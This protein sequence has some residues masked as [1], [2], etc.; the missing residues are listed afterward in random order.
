M[1]G[2]TRSHEGE[3]VLAVLLKSFQR[4]AYFP[5]LE[6]VPPLVVTHVRG[7][8]D[9]PAGVRAVPDSQ[10]SLERHKSLVRERVKVRLD[11]KEAV[12][13]AEVAIRAAALT[14][15]NP[16]DLINVALEELIAARLELPGFT[17]LE[18]LA[19]A[20]REEVNQGFFAGIERRASVL[21]K[22]RLLD[23]LH[24]DLYTRRSRFD[25]LKQPA[26]RPS[27]SRLKAHL[28][29][30]KE[31][32]EEF[33]ATTVWPR[34]GTEFWLEGVPPAKIVHFAGEARVMD[35]SEM[36]DFNLPKR[37]ALLACLVH[38]ARVRARDELAGML[39]RRMAALHKKG[40]EHLE[41]IRERERA[42]TERLWGVFGEVLAGARVAIGIEEAA[43]PDESAAGGDGEA[44]PAGDR[45]AGGESADRQSDPDTV[46]AGAGPREQAPDQDA[47]AD[48]GTATAAG[49][50][51]GS[52]GGGAGEQELEEEIRAL[53]QLAGEL[54]LDPLVKAG[55]VSVVSEQHAEISAHHGN[56]YMPLLAKYFK[57]HRKALFDLLDQ[58]E[59][60]S[61]S[62]DISVLD[63][64]EF[65]KAHRP[66]TREF[67][68]DRLKGG[69][70]PL[71]TRFCSR[72]WAAVIRDKAH[73]GMFARRH[74][75]VC[76]F[77]YL[78]SELKT[79]DIA[80]K[81]ADSYGNFLAQLMTAAEVEPLIGRYCAEAGL[82]ASASAFRQMIEDKLKKTTADVDAG[83]P[84]NTDLDIDEKT[85]QP[86]L[87][88]RR[89]KER[90]A[91]AI[92]LERAVAQR[93]QEVALLDIV[94]RTAHWTGWWR[95]F[96]P[97]SG[98]DPKISDP[99]GRYSVITF[100]YGT[101][102]GPYQ[103]SRHLRGAVSPHEISAPGNKHVNAARLVQ[104]SG[105]LTDAF[106]RLDVARLWGDG[107]KVGADGT[108]MDTWDDNLLAETSVRYGGYGGIA[109]RHIADSYIALFS[110]FIPCGVWE[111]VYL[112]EGL[113]EHQ[114]TSITPGEIHADTQGQSL[115]VF[116]LATMLGVE[117]LPRIRNWKDLIF[118]RAGENTA[119]THIGT[120]FGDDVID[121]QLIEDH[122]IDLMRVMVSIREGRISSSVLLRRLGNESR[123]NR[124]Y[125][126][127]RELGRA[128]RTIT[129]LRYLSEP[130]LR[131]S[132][133]AI[134]NRVEAFHGFA[135]WLGFGHDGIITD[136]DPDHMEKLVKFNELLANSV[137][138][139]NAVELTVL[140]NQLKAEGSTVRAEDVATLSPYTTR[141][142]RR[143]G[144]Y[145]LDLSP[146]AETV[147]EHL[148]L[149]TGDSSEGDQHDR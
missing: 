89:G 23:L 141:H 60:E 83:Y 19:G 50:D 28:E 127:F 118:Y 47:A 125:K 94:T 12:R 56:N 85:G 27:L 99:L 140:L 43:A 93:R 63:A 79:G 133:T 76:V 104:A 14:K 5:R 114:S 126:A 131:E 30:L 132:I 112:F 31:L 108:Q 53:H 100:T 42:E 111:A 17:T 101:N 98:S 120:L 78:A 86:V 134:T 122:W 130:Q 129:L 20:L 48:P 13:I 32:D 136:N 149:D 52:A 92:W 8:L 38:V 148:D 22:A 34:Y 24:V 121:W 61:T 138:F 116:G 36:G 68:P 105:D 41:E 44:G 25:E 57:S 119:F 70:E 102:M 113:L 66:L 71:D 80:V 103:M 6:E 135:K 109:Y 123:K 77:S 10:R 11:K 90:T 49:T 88:R 115:P 3:L 37:L 59:L 145:V 21:G 64:V 18:E 106:M 82:P 58:V 69:A 40:R 95:R 9:V 87:K 33:G 91:S 142:I 4:L 16:A 84:D 39:C 73:P 75:E 35:A 54:M 51:T 2:A 67:I 15:D 107:S 97:L 46:S 139:F 7:C 128:V 72:N 1:R 110:R 65:I 144:D 55:G 74:L 62:S 26:R 146:P 147:H 96:G 137:I 45:A 29:W 81:G 124:I 117:L 143:F